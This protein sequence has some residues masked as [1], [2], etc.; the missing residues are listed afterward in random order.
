M[1]ILIWWPLLL[2]VAIC[3]STIWI[4]AAQFGSKSGR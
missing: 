3:G 1:G 2:Y 4:I